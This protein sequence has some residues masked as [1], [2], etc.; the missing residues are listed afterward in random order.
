MKWPDFIGHWERFGLGL[1][2]GE[3]V[4]GLALPLVAV[5]LLIR[6][7][8]EIFCM[9]ISI[10]NWIARRWF[11]RRQERVTRKFKWPRAL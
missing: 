4:L 2:W 7:R 1:V 3:F 5:L 11:L 9:L 10:C 8:W 6:H